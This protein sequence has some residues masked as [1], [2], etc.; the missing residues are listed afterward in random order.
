MKRL[1]GNTG[2]L[3]ADQTRGLEALYRRRVPIQHLISLQ[4]LREI[5]RLSR[6]MRRQIGLLIDRTGRVT[7]V[8]VGDY[9]KIVIPDLTGY[10][11]ASGRLNGV[12]CVHTHL[13]EETLTEDDLTDLC[14]LTLDFMAA[15]TVSEDG[16]PGLVHAAHILPKGP[17][18]KPYGFLHPLRPDRMDIACLDRIHA[19]ET[20][21]SL[22]DGIRRTKP[23]SERAILMHDGDM[24]RH[25]KQESHRELLALAMSCGLEVVG[26][27]PYRRSFGSQLPLGKGKLQQ[28][29]ISALQKG[30]TMV[31]FDQELNPSQIRTLADRLQLKI[32]DRTQLIL[33]IFAQRAQTREGKL[34]VE[35]AQ[36]KYLLPRLVMKNTAMSRLTGGIGGRGPGETKLE[37]NRRRARDRIVRLEEALLQVRKNRKTQRA[38]R[39]KKH[40]PV[41]S[42]IGYTNAGKSTLLNTLTHSQVMAE[43]RLFATLDPTSRRLRFPQDME[44]IIT[45]T[46]GFIRDLPQDLMV[47]FRATL[48]E[49]EQADLLLHVIDI[50]HPHFP[51]QV[52]SVEMILNELAL[53]DKPAI[54]VLNKIDQLEASEVAALSRRYDG[55]P[56]CARNRSTLHGLID[57]MQG[58]LSKI[59]F[60]GAL[61]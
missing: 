30:V 35:L 50:S 61:A 37:I 7:H 56:I 27:E 32:I 10:R 31:V 53:M 24:P 15:V 29:A 58:I 14:L 22:F 20:E 19:L 45:D 28:L 39:G 57:A 52:E 38:M 54:R 16:E 2:G 26:T 41:V 34:Q 12:R 36:L 44:V 13:A 51:E 46:V 8:I 4:L 1:F 5:S 18:E 25:L 6:E 23:G 48:E 42:I 43:S 40:L 59:R 55:V 17:E 9:Q 49:L 47:A 60:R 11:S 21:L 3:K 33:D